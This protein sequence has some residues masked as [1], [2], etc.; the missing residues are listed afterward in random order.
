MKVSEITIRVA[1]QHDAPAMIPLINEAFL[2]EDFLEG[3]RT[4]AERMAKSM[5]TGQLL[6]AEDSAGKIV[7]TIYIELHGQRGYFGMLAVDP[8]QQGKGL[9]RLMIDAAEDYC[10]K[11]GCNYMDIKVLS[12]RKGLPKY[13]RQFGY[14]ETGTDGFRPSRLFKPGVE[15]HCIVMSKKLG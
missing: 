11:R 12:L 4:D 7:A 15:C 10:R 6:V 3:T 13:Y 1:T 8:S 9:G 2:V 14:I 5:E